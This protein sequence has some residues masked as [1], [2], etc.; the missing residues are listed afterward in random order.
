MSKKKY[1]CQPDKPRYL[2]NIFRN[3]AETALE[4]FVEEAKE[5][6]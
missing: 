2:L 4:D 6:A 3:Q 1:R 5:D